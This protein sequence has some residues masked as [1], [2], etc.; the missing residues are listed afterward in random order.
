[1]P[2]P[3]IFGFRLLARAIKLEKLAKLDRVYRQ[4]AIRTEW[5]TMAWGVCSFLL[6]GATF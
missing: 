1:M 5:I 4:K 2:I 3:S 6:L